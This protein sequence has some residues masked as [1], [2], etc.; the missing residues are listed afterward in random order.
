MGFIVER[1]RLNGR[2]RRWSSNAFS[3]RN[4]SGG[5][6]GPSMLA[7]ETEEEGASKAEE[8]AHKQYRE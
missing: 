7:P 6:Y 2:E 1:F 5:C 4:G 8:E 3:W